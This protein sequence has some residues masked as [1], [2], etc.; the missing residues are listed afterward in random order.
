MNA[1]ID[2]LAYQ[3]DLKLVVVAAVICLVSSLLTMTLLSGC[4]DLGRE[5]D[6]G[7][8]MAAIAVCAIGVWATHFVAILAYDTGSP[9]RYNPGFTALSAGI[10]LMTVGCGLYL[11]AYYNSVVSYALGGAYCGLGIAEM[12]LLG[13]FAIRSERWMIL[14]TPSTLI[15]IGAGCA[16]AAGAMATLVCFRSRWRVPASGLLMVVAVC[17]LHFISMTWTRFVPSPYAD[18]VGRGLDST[19]LAVLVF[20]LWAG[21]AG[22]AASRHLRRPQQ[23]ADDIL[24][25]GALPAAA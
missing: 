1:I 20:S 4:R 23:D 14:D 6:A 11:S 25:D 24:A 22:L 8:L 15:A 2:C 19:L 17:C 10:S 9:V 13:M 7:R 5:A 18:E 21:I 12:H 3:H 16:I